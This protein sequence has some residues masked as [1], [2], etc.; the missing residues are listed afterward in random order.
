MRQYKAAL[1]R[2]GKLMSHR[3]IRSA[4]PAALWK[5]SWDWALRRERMQ[6]EL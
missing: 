1:E 2:P 5:T 6:A 3:L 4:Q